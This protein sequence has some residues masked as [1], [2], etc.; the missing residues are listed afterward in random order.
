[1]GLALGDAIAYALNEKPQAAPPPPSTE[2]KT[3]TR[4]Q[5]EVAD[6]PRA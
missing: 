1:M 2:T 3:L 6:S 4:R 5:Q